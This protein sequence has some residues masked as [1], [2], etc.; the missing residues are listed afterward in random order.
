MDIQRLARLRRPAGTTPPPVIYLLAAFRIPTLYFPLLAID[1]LGVSL[2]LLVMAGLN[3]L[4]YLDRLRIAALVSAT[5]LLA[6]LAFTELSLKFGPFFYGYGFV[7][8]ML[9]STLLVLSVTD[10]ALEKLNYTTFM[11]S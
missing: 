8:A 10:R 1:S 5:M 11:L 2:Q 6:N 4:F 3:I 9:T 7:L